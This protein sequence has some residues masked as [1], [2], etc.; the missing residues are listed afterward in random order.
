MKKP[1]ATNQAPAAIGPYSQAILAG[2]ILFL[3]GQI[4]IDPATSQLVQGSFADEVEQI[5]KNIT[6]VLAAAGLTLDNVVKTTIFLTDPGDFKGVNEVY[7]RY[8]D[9]TPPARS[10]VVVKELPFGARVEIETIAVR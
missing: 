3:S 7:G 5:M 4:A 2:D 9:E 8:F 6:A 1:I 10:T